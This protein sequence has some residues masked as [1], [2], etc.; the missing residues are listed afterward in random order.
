MSGLLILFFII[1]C[2]ATFAQSVSG[3]LVNSE[4]MQPVEYANVGIVGKNTGTV[5]DANGNFILNVDAQF[6]NDTLLFSV[7]GYEKRLIKISDLRKN[8]ENI[9]QLDKRIYEL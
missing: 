1:I 9:I 8:N 7:I 2:N 5:T 4:S 3:I 6:D